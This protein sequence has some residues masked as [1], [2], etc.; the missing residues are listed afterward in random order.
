MATFLRAHAA[1]FEIVAVALGLAFAG[2]G[3]DNNS[4]GSVQVS[5]NVEP[6]GPN[7]AAG[8]ERIDVTEAE[9]P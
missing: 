2:C 5:V 4:A 1:L 9:P 6:P 7:C 3:D 8:G